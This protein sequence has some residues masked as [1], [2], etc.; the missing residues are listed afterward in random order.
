MVK[1]LMSNVC[2]MVWDKDNGR[3]VDDEGKA[4]KFYTIYYEK[5]HL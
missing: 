2:E 3:V 4:G 5:W 1:Q